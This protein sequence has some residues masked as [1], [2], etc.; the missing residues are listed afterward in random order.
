MK[1]IIAVMMVLVMLFTAVGCKKSEDSS[2]NVNSTTGTPAATGEAATDGAGDREKIGASMKDVTLN[3]RVMNE[4]T[5]LDKVIAK[6]DEL[7]K[8]DP[9]MSKIHLNFSY[10]TGADYVDKLQMA[11]TAQEDYDL[12]FCGSWQGLDGY[13]SQGLF[14]D[15]TKYFNNDAFPGLKA[16]FS[17]DYIDAAKTTVKNDDGEYQ[18]VL[19]QVPLATS[20]EEIRGLAYREDLR[21]KYNCPEITDDAS[22]KTYIQTVLANEPDMIGWSMWGGFFYN[23]SARY[24]GA[25]NNVYW[26]DATQPFGEETPFYVGISEDGTKVLNAVVMG[27][28]AEEFAKMPQGYN[29]DFIKAYELDRVSKWSDVLDPNRGVDSGSTVTKDAAVQYCGLSEFPSQLK[30][31]QDKYPDASLGFYVTEADQRNLKPGAI[32]S[33]MKTNNELVIPE[34]SDKVDATMYFL[35]WMFGTREHNELFAYGIEGDDWKAVGDDGMEFINEDSSTHYTMP[36][37]SLTLNP[38]YVRANKIYREDE[39]LSKYYNYSMDPT[40]Y[41][42]SLL[43]GFTFNTSNVETEV[44][45]ITALSSEL[46]TRYAL[47]GDKTAAKIDEWHAAAEDA[48][49]ENVRKELITQ[50]QAFLDL[51]QTLK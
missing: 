25:L 13:I 35:D 44:A 11:M 29:T 14:A 7:T 34:W 38:S 43:S 40:T 10:V 47:Y 8:D 49:L 41:K 50:V 23:D 33:S 15:I 9:I 39:Q 24:S 1:R 16:A 6:Y 22:L 12:L 17:E 45:G 5:N 48:G 51:Q 42:K 26:V 37:Y 19:Y 21:K 36:V 4:Y 46:M 20:F 2:K 30:T 31:L 3:I 32:V 27:D 28:S 18:Q